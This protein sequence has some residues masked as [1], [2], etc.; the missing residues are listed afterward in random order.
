MKKCDDSEEL[1]SGNCCDIRL[2]NKVVVNSVEPINIGKKQY[3][4]R[5]D[6]GATKSSIC[7]SVARKLKLGPALDKV[8][9]KNSHGVSFRDIIMVEV[10]FA[11]IKTKIKFNVSDRAH[12]RYPI[13]IGRNL[14][15]KG[16]LV[17]CS[18]EDRDN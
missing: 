12:M 2:N 17:D 11:G 15:K 13:L 8:E 6:T 3:L 7:K 10:G 5:I 16:F 14:L 9:V 4:A 18:N 1:G